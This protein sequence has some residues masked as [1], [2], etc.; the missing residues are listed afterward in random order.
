M[1]LKLK[2]K[3]ILIALTIASLL[4][5]CQ[6]SVSE[7]NSKEE[8]S[9][10]AEVEA[11]EKSEDTEEAKEDSSENDAE[12]KVENASYT[13]LSESEIDYSGKEI[14]KV[15]E[16]TGPLTDYDEEAFKNEPAY[17]K[18]I[19]VSFGGPLCVSTTILA[20]VLGYY[21]D[22][23]IEIEKVSGGNSV[24]LAGTGKID[25]GAS[26]IAASIVPAVNGTNIKFFETTQTGCQ[27]LLVTADSPI[28]STKDLVGKKIGLPNG[29][30]SPDHN[31]VIRF[32][33][34]DGIDVD[35]INWVP[36]ELSAATQALESGEVDACLMPDQYSRS[37]RNEGK[38]NIIRS[39]T[40]DT[41]FTE[42]PCCVHFFNGD[43][44]ENNPIHAAKVENALKRTNLY[45][46]DNMEEA[47]QLI[48]ENNLAAGDLETVLQNMKEYHW[49]VGDDILGNVLKEV[50]EDY[51]EGG[52]IPEDSNVDEILDNIYKPMN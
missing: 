29:I 51:K 11:S 5:G 19:G 24:E 26:H 36:V 34:R 2:L 49:V 44:L 41:D 14:G 27:S 46:S 16:V 4:A 38:L 43:F 20:D 6:T 28:K 32:L 3:K 39:I 45:V 42:E 13:R 9:E 1:T 50:L 48:I 31:I 18:P 7:S 22:E 47:A 52:V 15:K 30:G 35:D 8:I 17:G 37:F 23:G 33:L 25:I 21:K 10:P 40:Y 12:V